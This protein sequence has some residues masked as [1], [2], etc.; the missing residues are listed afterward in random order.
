MP[1]RQSATWSASH[2][3]DRDK[4]RRLV[5]ARSSTPLL[6]RRGGEHGS[7]LGTNRRP[8]KRTFAWLKRFRRLRIRTERRADIGRR[9][10]GTTGSPRHARL[11]LGCP[12]GSF[13]TE[14]GGLT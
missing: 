13:R 12:A 5:R 1:Y 9:T 2:V 11:R 14:S 3:A 10:D 6:A 8:V 7:G 4:D